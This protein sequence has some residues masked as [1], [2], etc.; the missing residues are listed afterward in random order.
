M[1]FRVSRANRTIIGMAS[2]LAI[3]SGCG[4]GDE[5]PAAAAPAPPPAPAAAAPPAAPPPPP[6]A[7]TTGT[8]AVALSWAA[9]TQYENGS[10]FVD[11]AGYRIFYGSAPGTYTKLVEIAPGT[12]SHNIQSLPATTHY[13]TISAYNHEGVESTLSNEVA[14]SLN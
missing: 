4:G 5:E 8:R 10:P 6:P 3:L 13:F 12:T 1:G 11:L 7:A 9:P 14:I 2:I